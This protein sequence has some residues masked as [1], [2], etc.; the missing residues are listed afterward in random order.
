[1]LKLCITCAVLSVALGLHAQAPV[2]QPPCTI[3]SEV[4]GDSQSPPVVVTTAPNTDMGAVISNA[5]AQAVANGSNKVIV[6]SGGRAPMTTPVVLSNLSNF[7]LQL[8]PGTLIWGWNLSQ[9]MFTVLGGNNV[10]IMG[11]SLFA[12]DTGTNGPSCI[13][14]VGTDT[15]PVNTLEL[16]GTECSG[17]TSNGISVTGV[18]STATSYKNVQNVSIHNEFVHDTGSLNIYA[19]GVS[20]LCMQSNVLV[21]PANE[22]IAGSGAPVNTGV[23]YSENVYFGQNYV[24]GTPTFYR[25]PTATNT[26]PSGFYAFT[27]MNVNTDTNTFATSLCTLALCSGAGDLP[28][29]PSAIHDDTVLNAINVNN[30]ISSYGPG[31]TC[32]VS[33]SCNVVGGYIHDVYAYALYDQSRSDE[34]VVNALTST[35]GLVVDQASSLQTVSDVVNGVSTPVVQAAVPGTGVVFSQTLSSLMNDGMEPFPEIWVKSAKGQPADG[36]EL[37][38][39]ADVNIW[40]VHSKLALPALQAGE[41]TR[42]A[43]PPLHISLMGLLGVRTWAIVNPGNPNQDTLSISDYRQVADSRNNTYS[44]VTIARTGAYPLDVSGCGSK[45]TFT[46]NTITDPGVMGIWQYTNSGLMGQVFIGGYPNCTRSD[47]EFISN[48]VNLNSPAIPL[49]GS[50]LLNLTNYGQNNS[51][52]NVTLNNDVTAGPY[53]S[54][55]GVFVINNQ[56]LSSTINA[57]AIFHQ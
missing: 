8:N 47:V 46:N 25:Q 15:M 10:K 37:W 32:E 38:L 6:N 7:T 51:I 5:V 18:G 56:G 14:V 52:A 17:T 21:N 9:P 42:V 31:I 49:G 1:M 55:P 57:P 34:V 54:L 24:A 29:T 45:T 53:A 19:S 50:S 13:N 40:D 16:S 28:S 12:G 11:G 35:A 41:W 36:Y 39:S 26:P 20:N 4:N 22:G 2:L 30:T 48:V 33:W 23:S 44:G 43:L 27:S 3:S